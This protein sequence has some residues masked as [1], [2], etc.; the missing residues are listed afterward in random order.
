MT[1][2]DAFRTGRS[3]NL[4]ALRLALAGCVIV[5]HAWPL[6]LGPGTTEPLEHLTGRSLGGWA[7]L[8]FFFLSGLLITAS[9]E[10]RPTIAF[11]RSRVRRIFP[12]LGVA[13][14]LTLCL[15]YACGATATQAEAARWWLRAFTLVSIEYRITDAFATNPY[16]GVVNG[17][18]WS[19]FHEVLA[20][21]VCMALVSLGVL[22]RGVWVLNL[23]TLAGIASLWPGTLS[24]RFA[25]FVPLFFAFSIGMVVHHLRQSLRLSPWAGIAAI[26]AAVLLPAP[27]SVPALCYGVMSITLCARPIRL[28]ADLS[29]GL[30]IYGWPVAQTVVYLLP[31]IAPVPL[32]ALSLVLT[33]PFA[34]FSWHG[35]EHP[36]L[37]RRKT[38]A[39]Q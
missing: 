32:A 33:I 6:A 25:T 18:L 4:D 29:Y 14:I 23:V 16:P 39:V 27:F 12:G 2:A 20:Y 10:R 17:P 31:S 9:A 1:L 21:G 28:S 15:A 8:L 38:V 30:Y 11:W 34:V 22:R 19:L 13:L 37:T 36:T 24:P 35:V 7:V 5:S 26:C 3:G